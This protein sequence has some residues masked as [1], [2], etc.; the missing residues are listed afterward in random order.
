MLAPLT[1]TDGRAERVAAAGQLAQHLLLLAGA[2]IKLS[3]SLLW[4]AVCVAVMWGLLS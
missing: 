1:F 3:F 4:V 2:L